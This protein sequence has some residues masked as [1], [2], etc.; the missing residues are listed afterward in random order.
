MSTQAIQNACLVFSMIGDELH[1]P[2]FKF[3]KIVMGATT[4]PTIH[5]HKGTFHA[6]MVNS[7]QKRLSDNV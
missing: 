6:D 1:D 7:F 4:K 3:N 5:C 2:E